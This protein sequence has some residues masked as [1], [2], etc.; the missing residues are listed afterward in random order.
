[1]HLPTLAIQAA[2]ER[3][4]IEQAKIESEYNMSMLHHLDWL[5]KGMKVSVK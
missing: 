5:P 1:M 4:D 2:L 3:R